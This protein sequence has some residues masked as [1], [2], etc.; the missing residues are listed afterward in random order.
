M[1]IYHNPRCRKSRET[2]QLIKDKGVTVEI[3]EYLNTSPSELQLKDIL[4]KLGMKAIEI[5]RKGEPVF[6][7]NFKGKDFSEDQWIRILAEN[8]ILIERPIV[9]KENEAVIGRPPENVL[10]LL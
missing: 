5:V 9:V 2:L 1:I 7:E 8:P 6:K 10:K 3:V 4:S